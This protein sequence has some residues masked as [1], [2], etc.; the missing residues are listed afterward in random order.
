MRRSTVNRSGGVSPAW[1]T[2]IIG[3]G[4]AVALAMAGSAS[5]AGAAKLF[6]A[7]SGHSGRLDTRCLY[8]AYSSI[9]TAVNAASSGD[10]VEVCPG[11]YNEQVT[12]STSNLTINGP[13]T[14]PVIDPT[15][16]TP[17]TVSDMDSGQTI[18]P[19][20]DVTPGTTGVTLN[21]LI[22]DGSGLTPS[23]SSSGCADDF[24][25]VL[26]QAASGK[27]TASAVQNITLGPGLGGCQDGL[28]VFV[29]A[30]SSG[31]ANVAMRRDSVSNY[32]KNGITCV[33][34][35]TACTLGQDTA[36]GAGPSSSVGAQNGVQIGPGATGTLTYTTATGHDWTGGTNS[37]EPQAD[38]AAGILLYGAGGTTTISHSNLTDDQI[39]IE[40]VDSNAKVNSDTI[41]Q[42]GAGIAGSAGVFDVP[43]DF[44]CSSLSLS[45]GTTHLGLAYTTVS[46]SGTPSG[47]YGIWLGDSWS[48][49]D[50]WGS[51]GTVDYTAR[52]LT[53]SGATNSFVNGPRADVG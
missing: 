5:A 48:G 29:Q 22:V 4:V 11:T 19:I 16:S 6:V 1:V 8:A 15:T 46:Y 49:N 18:V 41:S 10:T 37:T 25:G 30:G 53:I 38:D 12:V 35:G 43:C 13:G 39:G 21:H 31:T 27:L 20:I 3:V 26:Y 28:A 32:D 45:P 23:F 2:R 14:T 24:V 17:S 50:P 42:T 36:T 34:A 9:Q 52:H 47:S 51:G 33:D 7:P 44:Y 40:I